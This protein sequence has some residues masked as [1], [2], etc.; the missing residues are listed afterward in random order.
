[1][2]K[3]IQAALPGGSV[4]FAG[5]LGNALRLTVENRLKKV[6]YEKLVRSFRDHEDG[7]SRW[8][9]EFWGKIVRSAIRVLQSNP[10]PELE[11]MVRDAVRGLCDCIEP[12]GCISTYP[13]EKRLQDWDAWGRKY[14]ILGL[15][16][17]YR[18]VEQDP[19]VLET[20][21]RMTA[22]FIASF[23]GG[24]RPG[25]KLRWHD[26]MPANSILGAVE[27]AARLTG[28]PSFFAWAKRLAD[29]GC[30]NSMDIFAESRAGRRPADLGNGKAYE[31]TSCFEGLLEICRD[32]GDT[33]LLE[34]SLNYFRDIVRYELFV[35]G[36]A[37]L[38]DCWGEFWDHGALNQ[39]NPPPKT[40]LGETC[41]TTTIL[42][43]A[44][45]LLRMNGDSR[46][47][48][49][50]E[51]S[52][53]NGILGAM[54][55]DGSWWNHRNLTP[56]TEPAYKWPAGD[57][58]QGYGEDC[59][60]AQGPEALGVGG[61]FAVMRRADG[62][63]VNY[64]EAMEVNSEFGGKP[65][66]FKI[67]GGYPDDGEIRMEIR[68]AAPVECTLALRIPGWCEDPV[69][70][71]DGRTWSPAAGRYAELLRTWNDGDVIRLSLPMPI[72]RVSAPDN[73]GRFAV[74]RGPVLLVQDARICEVGSPCVLT[75]DEP[76]RITHPGIRAAY[77]WPNGT[78]L[79]D[80][81]SAGNLFEPEDT[82]CVWLK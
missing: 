38:K 52:L 36:A 31:M 26:G 10:D 14:A 7:D 49:V 29:S 69:L 19:R 9:G 46:I 79:C 6:D 35:T 56:L 73:S 68:S 41:I 58:I 81:A 32:N 44:N 67:T 80:Y 28:E 66:G 70:E 12:D 42:R 2:Y 4:K 74:R 3:D 13:K 63:A 22:N 5:P 72:V 60:L 15:C 59:C 75:S 37:G 77:E 33:S 61:Q 39:M 17:Y 48:D 25:D 27:L 24:A 8:R 65:F 30:A 82:V 78:R 11:K 53:V 18:Y 20:I 43:F 40:A 50:M 54:K 57:Q 45:H 47:A 76:K 64:F 34:L 71:L 21:R 16:R 55:F 51:Y 1:M 62:F 23:P